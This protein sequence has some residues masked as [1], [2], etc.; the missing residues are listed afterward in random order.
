[1]DVDV[2]PEVYQGRSKL[3]ALPSKYFQREYFDGTNPECTLRKEKM[4]TITVV[5]VE[6]NQEFS[7]ALKSVLETQTL[8]PVEVHILNPSDK[9]KYTESPTFEEFYDEIA[10]ITEELDCYGLVLL[11][12]HLNWRWEGANLAPSLSNVVSISTEPVRWTDYSFSGKAS[13]AFQND[14]KAKEKFLA[15]L[16]GLLKKKLPPEDVQELMEVYES[17]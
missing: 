11:D 6:D 13:I 17:H 9:E 5:I 10:A 16:V 14:E 3:I 7:A 15:V 8:F 2:G 12:N 1:M 4:E